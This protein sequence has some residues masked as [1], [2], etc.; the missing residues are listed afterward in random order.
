M[1][2]EKI[3][4]ILD[5]FV[6]S[7][8]WISLAAL[9]I[10]LSTKLLFDLNPVFNELLLV[11][12][13]TFI[14]YN[15][16]KLKGLNFEANTSPFCLWMREHKNSIYLLL[17]LASLSLLYAL[18][19]VSFSQL[20]IL[21]FTLLI[22]LIYMGIERFSLRTFW[23]FKTQLVAFVWAV[24]ILGIALGDVWTLY[25]IT[26][27]F[28]WF[29]AVFFLI[30]ALTIPFEIRDWKVDKLVPKL[31]TIPMVFGLKGTL[32]LSL[33]HLILSLLIFLLFDTSSMLLIP[34]FTIM[35]IIIY[36]LN[37]D[38][39]EYKYTLVLD[40]LIILVYPLLLLGKQLI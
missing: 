11:F 20:V 13:A 19:Q 14:G 1:V 12:S 38:S 4:P 18:S 22:S 21:T 28:I 15:V 26:G 23:F 32:V 7:N 6:F 36:S 33:V 39:H 25:Q 3:K 30:L 29:S 40:G 37:Q 2:W 35:G 5:A 27:I 17:F 9:S 8:T 16:L 10:Y 24:F 31:K 34:L